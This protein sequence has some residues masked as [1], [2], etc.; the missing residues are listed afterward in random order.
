MN[1]LEL[2]QDMFHPFLDGKK[3][4]LNAGEVMNLWHYLNGAQQF[5]KEEQF[6]YSL[7]QD[8][9]LKE[10]LND[11]ITNIHRPIVKELFDFLNNEG[12]SLSEAILEDTAR[13]FGELPAEA[14][15][16][17]EEFANQLLNNISL[18]ITYA[19]R[20]LAESVRADVCH[21]FAKFQMMKVMFGISLKPLM[22]KRGWLKVP[23]Y[24]TNSTAE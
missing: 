22:E 13:H 20:G 19:A 5:L 18:G 3:P 6:A 23:P 17:D 4:P 24:F 8:E 14:R 15:L 1:P 10:K 7:V 2:I 9:E 12:V 11:L 16:T 21:K